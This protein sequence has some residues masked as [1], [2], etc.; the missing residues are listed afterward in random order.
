MKSSIPLLQKLT[1]GCLGLLILVP[2]LVL[3]TAAKAN[4]NQTPELGTNNLLQQSMDQKIIEDWGIE[5]VAMRTTAAGH[6][7]DFRF[8]VVDAEKA[9]PLLK[10]QTKRYLV[11]QASGKVL[12]VPNTAKVGLLSNSTTN[13]QNGRTYWMFFGNHHKLVQ[14]GDKVTV[15]IGEFRAIDLEVE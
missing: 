14:K 5:L 8:R 2:F 13:P 9:A 12:S 4:T 3:G 7:V 10:Q 11:H 6:M 15:A 1:P